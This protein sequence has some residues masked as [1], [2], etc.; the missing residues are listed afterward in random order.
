MLEQ[1]TSI[2]NG[3]KF[4]PVFVNDAKMPGTGDAGTPLHLYPRADAVQH[5]EIAGMRDT[6]DAYVDKLP[7]WMSQLRRALGHLNWPEEMRHIPHDAVVHASVRER[8]TLPGVVK[9]EGAGAYRP[10]ALRQHAEFG[11]YYLD[12]AS[13]PSAAAGVAAPRHE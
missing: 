9:A 6:I 1:A 13:E 3:I 5:S 8:F 11:R 2:P 7:V 10:K 4:G 12:A